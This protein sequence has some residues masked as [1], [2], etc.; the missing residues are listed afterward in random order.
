MRREDAE[1]LYAKARNLENRARDIFAALND[2]ELPPEARGEDKP[3]QF[4]VVARRSLKYAVADLEAFADSIGRF[5]LEDEAG[6]AQ[7]EG[8]E[9]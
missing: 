2:L 6:A 5:P 3:G 8:R 1:V 7:E 4:R 9:P